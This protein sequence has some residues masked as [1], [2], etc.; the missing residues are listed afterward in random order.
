MAPAPPAL[1]VAKIEEF[2]AA[3]TWA[4]QQ[5]WLSRA[6]SDVYYAAFHGVLALLSTA[7]LE[8]FTHRGTQ[9]LLALHFV[10]TGALPP[11]TATIFGRLAADRQ[12]ADYS[13]AADVTDSAA[14]RAVADLMMI[15]HP[16]LALL[17]ERIDAPA[18]LDTAA[19]ALGALQAAAAARA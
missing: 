13:V 17:R 10:H 6:V 14:Q 15:M 2:L 16:V 3:A 19:R 7:G 18:E 8:A 11:G 4:V 1:H 9:Q 5:G 12:F